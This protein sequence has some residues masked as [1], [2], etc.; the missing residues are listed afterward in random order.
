MSVRSNE[1]LT[2][3]IHG[4]RKDEPS[5]EV[6]LAAINALYNSLEF[7]RDNFEREVCVSY[8][9]LYVHFLTCDQGERNYIMQVVCEATQ[10]PNVQVQVGAFECLVRIM[11]LY[12]D[13]MA[14]Y[15]ERALFGVSMLLILKFSSTNIVV[16]VDCL[17]NETQRRYH[18]PSSG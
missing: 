6:Q 7:V 14:F 1:I 10:N 16:L 3:V 5:S 2:A 8:Y 4:A 11:S 9:I 15:M 12:Y 17:R 13:K 18:R